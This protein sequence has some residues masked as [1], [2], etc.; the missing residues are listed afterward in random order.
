MKKVLTK[1]HS[2]I[3]L[4]GQKEIGAIRR[5]KCVRVGVIAI[6]AFETKMKIPMRKLTSDNVVVGAAV[7]RTTGYP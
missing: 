2:A 6:K 5:Y 7:A 3:V 1:K 4:V